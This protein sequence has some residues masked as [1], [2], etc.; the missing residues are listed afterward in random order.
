MVVVS[1]PLS[2]SSRGDVRACWKESIERYQSLGT[3]I[4]QQFQSLGAPINQ[5]FQSLGAPI[6]QQFQSLGAPINRTIGDQSIA[7]ISV[8]P[9]Y[10]SDPP[11]IEEVKEGRQP[12]DFVL[13]GLREESD[14]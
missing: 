8:R 1:P 13:V 7:R 9:T 10:P 5:Q 12:V 6:N 14:V 4:N 3:P 11:F 2:T